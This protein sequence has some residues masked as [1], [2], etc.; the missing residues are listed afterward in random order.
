MTAGTKSR[1]CE[2]TRL[3]DCAAAHHMNAKITV[4]ANCRAGEHS[5][6]RNVRF[7]HE[8][9]SQ[10]RLQPLLRAVP[11]DASLKFNMF[12]S[13]L[14]SNF[15]HSYHC[16]LYLSLTVTFQN[17]NKKD[18]VNGNNRETN[19]RPSRISFYLKNGFVIK[20]LVIRNTRQLDGPF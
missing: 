14:S 19:S 1:N 12:R 10:T 15:T 11:S 16:Q 5:N 9:P 8:S 18:S 4:S 6:E 13:L 17:P 20:N 2:I 3:R 7:D